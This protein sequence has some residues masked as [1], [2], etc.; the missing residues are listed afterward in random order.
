MASKS[1]YIIC[2]YSKSLKFFF[3]IAILEPFR[4]HFAKIAHKVVK[5]KYFPNIISIFKM[6]PTCHNLVGVGSSVLKL[7]RGGAPPPFIM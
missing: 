1:L 4:S 6:N 3:R 2:L 7:S 5:S